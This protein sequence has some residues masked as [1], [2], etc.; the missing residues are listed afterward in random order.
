MRLHEDIMKSITKQYKLKGK[1]NEDRRGKSKSC[2]LQI[3]LLV[4]REGVTWRKNP[5]DTVFLKKWMGVN[6]ENASFT[7]KIMVSWPILALE[8]FA[9]AQE[10]MR[11]M[12]LAWEVQTHMELRLATG[13]IF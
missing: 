3:F 7:L 9:W 8:S 13:N 11:T 4:F 10:K 1:K 12:T 2:L 6:F 5:T